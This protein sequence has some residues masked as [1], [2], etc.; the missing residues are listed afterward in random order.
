MMNGIPWEE[1]QMQTFQKIVNTLT[2]NLGYTIVLLIA[3][4]L[5]AIFS[6]GLLAGLITAASALI[7]YIC[8]NVLYTEFKKAPKS[9]KK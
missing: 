6:N 4:A 5:F 9:K 7:A 1:T 8:V 2:K 3:I